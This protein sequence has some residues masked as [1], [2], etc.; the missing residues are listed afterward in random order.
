MPD[1]PGGSIF[2]FGECHHGR[3][4]MTLTLLH[5]A[6]ILTLDPTNPQIE[7]GYV[8]VRDSR[9]EAAAAGEYRGAEA[10]DRRIDCGGKLIAP[11]LINSHTHSQSSTMAGFGDRL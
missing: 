7:H 9:I 5:D 4:N 2:Q 3:C 1:I 6:M 10:P 8:L 11:G